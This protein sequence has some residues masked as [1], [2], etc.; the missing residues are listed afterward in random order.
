MCFPIASAHSGS[1]LRERLSEP[2]VMSLGPRVVPKSGERRALPHSVTGRTEGSNYARHGL[3]PIGQLILQA[4]MGGLVVEAR[5][6]G[7]AEQCP[8]RPREAL[9]MRIH[10]L[11]LLCGL[12]AAFDASATDTT[13]VTG[14]WKLTTTAPGGSYVAGIDPAVEQHQDG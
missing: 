12:C 3:P 7:F 2:R 5:S 6:R 4:N 14:R 1:S 9:F 8:L 13:A 11:L 10:A